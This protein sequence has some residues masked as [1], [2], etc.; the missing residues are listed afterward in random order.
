PRKQLRGQPFQCGQEVG[1]V[2]G[3]RVA[4]LL[5]GQNRHRQF[6]QVLQG[7]VIEMTGRG[8][9]DRRILTVAPKAAAVADAYHHW[10]GYQNNAGRRASSRPAAP[11]RVINGIASAYATVNPCVVAW[12]TCQDTVMTPSSAPCWTGPS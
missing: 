1:R 3:G 10:S 12:K 8:Q 9:L 4:L 11:L 6:G 5:D 7:E 2:S